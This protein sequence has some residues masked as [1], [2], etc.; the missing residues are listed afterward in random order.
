[1]PL[2]QARRCGRGCGGSLERTALGEQ[3]AAVPGAPTGV[4]DRNIELD[5]LGLICAHA[6]RIAILNVQMLE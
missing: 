2:T 1:M 4:G 5:S 3:R 6:I